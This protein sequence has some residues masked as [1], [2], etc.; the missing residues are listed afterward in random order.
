MWASFLNIISL[1]NTDVYSFEKGFWH[2]II[3]T[4]LIILK[5]FIINIIDIIM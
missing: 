3:R 1:G 2:Y 4:L 5:L